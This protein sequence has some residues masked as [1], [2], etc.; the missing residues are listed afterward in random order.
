MNNEVGASTAK[1]LELLT[2]VLN[3]NSDFSV[4]S[5]NSSSLTKDRSFSLFMKVVMN[6][7]TEG[8]SLPQITSDNLWREFGDYWRARK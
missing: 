3:S 8:K 4:P 6:Y 7:H 1:A 2:N 5:K